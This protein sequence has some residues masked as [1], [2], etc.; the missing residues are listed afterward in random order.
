MPT[1]DHGGLRPI[2]VPGTDLGPE[3]QAALKLIDTDCPMLFV[4]GRAGTGKTT[5]VRH[6]RRRPGAEKMVVLAPTGIAA[7]NAGGQTIH[8]FFACR[9]G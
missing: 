6:L 4:L 1:S 3:A 2:T 8:S 7:I 5:L 9:H